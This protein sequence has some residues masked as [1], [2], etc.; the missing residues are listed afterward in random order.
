MQ[1]SCA[2]A[3]GLVFTFDGELIKVAAADSVSPEAV[4]AT[5][6]DLPD[7][8]EPRQRA[9]PRHPHPSASFTY[10]TFTRTRNIA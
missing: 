3:P 2:T 5:P 10:R 9:A 1:R 7:A 6:P 8:T 4:E